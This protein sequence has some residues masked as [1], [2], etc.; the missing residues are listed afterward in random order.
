[1]LKTTSG[2]EIKLTKRTI[3]SCIAQIYDPVG[4]AAAFIIKAKIG[5]QRL[6]Q[7]GYGWDEEL[8]REVCDEWKESLISLKD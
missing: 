2:Q 5:M 1:M 7:K 8:P 3:L 4:I 6:W